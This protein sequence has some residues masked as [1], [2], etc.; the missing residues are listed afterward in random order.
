ML[1]AGGQP[2]Q[3][4]LVDA[5]FVVRMTAR[6]SLARPAARACG[7]T[8][9][10]PRV[11]SG[12]TGIWMRRYECRFAGSETVAGRVRDAAARAAQPDDHRDG[13][14]TRAR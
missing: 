9:W 1:L 6:S 11:A 8:T 3:R 5:V 14:G 13:D 10:R 4:R 2:L 12:R 7:P